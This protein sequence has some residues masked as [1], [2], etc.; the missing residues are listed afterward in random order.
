[1]TVEDAGPHNKKQRPNEIMM[2]GSGGAENWV[3]FI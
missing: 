2:A 1:M 3:I